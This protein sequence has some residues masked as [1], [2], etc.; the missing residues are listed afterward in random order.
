MKSC[1]RAPY[2]VC[3]FMLVMNMGKSYLLFKYE[4]WAVRLQPDLFKEDHIN[5]VHTIND[6][7]L[8][9]CEWLAISFNRRSSIKFESMSKMKFS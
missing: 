1:L 5:Y 7:C 3:N 4:G 6:L 9:I 8:V 2:Y